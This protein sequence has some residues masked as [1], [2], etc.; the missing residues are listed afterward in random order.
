MSLT[1]GF[2]EDR[3][4]FLDFDFSSADADGSETF[5]VEFDEPT[6]GTFSGGKTSNGIIRFDAGEADNISFTPNPHYSGPIT[7]SFEVFQRTVWS[8]HI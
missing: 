2:L 3:T 7:L 5:Y 1:E 6:K 8:R 4:N